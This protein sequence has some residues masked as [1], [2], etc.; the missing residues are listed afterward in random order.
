MHVVVCIC[1]LYVCTIVHS[2]EMGIYKGKVLEKGDKHAST[3]KKKDSINKGKKNDK[4]KKK[5]PGSRQ[6]H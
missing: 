5:K 6:R 1:Q 4:E 2:S 3:M